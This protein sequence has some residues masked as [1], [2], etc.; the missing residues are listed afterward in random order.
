MAILIRIAFTV[1]LFFTCSFSG[2]QDTLRRFSIGL[3]GEY[4]TFSNCNP[5]SIEMSYTPRSC[6]ASLNATFLPFRKTYD[7]QFREYVINENNTRLTFIGGSRIGKKKNKLEIGLGYTILI[8]N[9]DRYDYVYNVYFQ[10]DKGRSLTHFLNLHIGYRFAIRNT[11]SLKP[12]LQ[13][14][15]RMGNKTNYEAKEYIE[16]TSVSTPQTNLVLTD[17]NPML[18]LSLLYHFVIKKN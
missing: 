14:Y 4:R 12:E 3:G 7:S 5:I 8:S 1:F 10:K 17:F 16:F 18:K 11:F 2:A 9:F 13:L 15:Y 6:Y